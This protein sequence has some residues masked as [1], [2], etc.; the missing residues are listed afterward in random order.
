MSRQLARNRI[1]RGAALRAEH[2]DARTS[3]TVRN[4]RV[5]H[6]GITKFSDSD[7]NGVL[8]GEEFSAESLR[9]VLH[10]QLHAIL[11]LST[12]YNL[13]TARSFLGI[14]FAIILYCCRAE[15]LIVLY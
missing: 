8:S 14:V 1:H 5:L 7:G 9:V 13:L 3:P 12:S 6:E 2:L 10:E 15:F 4:R 11:Q